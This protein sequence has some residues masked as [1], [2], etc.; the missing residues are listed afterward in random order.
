MLAGAS[1]PVVFNLTLDLAD[2]EYPQVL[3]TNCRKFTVK[4]RTQGTSIKLA[5]NPNESG[6][7]YLTIK[8]SCSEDL[9]GCT[10]LVLYMQSE[11]PGTVVEIVAW[12]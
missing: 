8:G 6:V 12:C 9:I 11:T 4:T 5:F 1:S 10:Y 7:T 2:T 3:P